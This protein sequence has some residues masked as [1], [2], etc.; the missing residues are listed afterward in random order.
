MSVSSPQASD[1]RVAAASLALL[2]PPVFILHR[3]HGLLSAPLLDETSEHCHATLNSAHL[4]QVSAAP[5]RSVLGE[6]REKKMFILSIFL[7]PSSPPPPA[8]TL[9]RWVRANVCR[10]VSCSTQTHRETFKARCCRCEALERASAPAARRKQTHR[11]PSASLCRRRRLA[12]LPSFLRINLTPEL[13]GVGAERDRKL[14]C[15]LLLLGISATESA[16]GHSGGPR[17]P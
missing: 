3:L 17:E 13:T 2:L 12:L 6:N 4:Y 8:H 5:W 15:H 10:G 9:C 11:A 1:G 7:C 16:T 14:E